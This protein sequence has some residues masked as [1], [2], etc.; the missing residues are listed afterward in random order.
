MKM[1]TEFIALLLKHQVKLM[2]LNS[3]I[4]HQSIEFVIA[5]INKLIELDNEKNKTNEKRK[6][7]SKPRNGRVRNTRTSGK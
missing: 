2:Q 4:R 7:L 6:N 3:I 5:L 1:K